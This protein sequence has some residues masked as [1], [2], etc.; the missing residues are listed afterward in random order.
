MMRGVLPAV[1][2]LVCVAQSAG[3]QRARPV[4]PDLRL[5]GPA[6]FKTNEC[7]VTLNLES[8]SSRPSGETTVLI[9]DRHRL[10]V[11]ILPRI[12]G[13]P[14]SLTFVPHHFL[15]DGKSHNVELTWQ[16]GTATYQVVFPSSANPFGLRLPALLSPPGK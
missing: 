3:A 10:T 7:V 2:V 12:S 15:C 16:R 11:R 9:D 14:R 1:L 8:G 13:G 6:T 4:Q 5:R